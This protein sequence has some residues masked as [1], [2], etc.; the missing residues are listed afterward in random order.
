MFYNY[1]DMILAFFFTLL[2][3]LYLIFSSHY[4]YLH[5]YNKLSIL[6]SYKA[7]E[8]LASPMSPKAASINNAV[9]NRVRVVRL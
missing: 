6:V 1:L 8:F 2:T 3:C 5:F 7:L 9:W 4:Y